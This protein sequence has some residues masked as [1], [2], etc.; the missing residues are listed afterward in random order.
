MVKVLPLFN[1]HFM[2]FLVCANMFC[3]HSA[4]IALIFY[5]H[6]T[7]SGLANCI[8]YALASCQGKMARWGLVVQQLQQSQLCISCVLQQVYIKASFCST[9][10]QCIVSVTQHL[11]TEYT[12]LIDCRVFLLSQV[13]H[14]APYYPL[15]CCVVF[16]SCTRGILVTF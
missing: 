5:Y 3:W 12:C 8:T 7:Q 9:S 1:G 4:R 13:C 10:L 14:L 6:L 15:A 11:I 16:Q 2:K